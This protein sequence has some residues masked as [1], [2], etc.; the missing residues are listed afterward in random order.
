[1]GPEGAVNIIFRRD[2]AELA[3]AGRAPREA[4]HRLQGALRQPLLG[5]RARLH[6]RRDR[7]ARDAPEADPRA[8]RRCRPSASSS[9]SASTATSRFS[10]SSD[11]PRARQARPRPRPRARPRSAAIAIARSWIARPVESNSVIS[12]RPGAGPRPGRAGRRRAG[13]PRRGSTRPAATP[14]ASSPPSDGLLPTRRRTARQRSRPR[15][16][17]RPCPRASAP[18][19]AR[20]WPG[21][22]S[23]VEDDRLGAGRHACTTTSWRRPPR[24]RPRAPSRARPP[25]HRATSRA[26]SA[27]TPGP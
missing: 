14:P 8:A 26:G 27:Q 24:A 16:R 5:G 2:I 3:D 13:S 25:A 4:D 15:A 19:T 10:A 20:C 6:R 9:R 21:R 22:R 23:D 12:S 18:S 17:P 7:A 1:M 11:P